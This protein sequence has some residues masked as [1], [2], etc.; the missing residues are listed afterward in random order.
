M[1]PCYGA[2]MLILSNPKYA[3][4]TLFGPPRRRA[5]LSFAALAAL[6]VTV[7]LAV[8]ACGPAPAAGSPCSTEQDTAD[9]T[10]SEG[11]S[12]TQT[13]ERCI[14]G[15][16]LFCPSGVTSGE[17]FWSGCRP[18]RPA[19]FVADGACSSPSD[20]CSGLCSKGICLASVGCK[21]DGPCTKPDDCCSG[22][23]DPGGLCRHGTCGGS[24]TGCAETSQCC[25]GI[26]GSSGRCQSECI[27]AGQ[28]CTHDAQCCSKACDATGVCAAP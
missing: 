24:D 20:C 26:C 17:L 25:S 2:N 7:S 6:V 8:S 12:R 21:T 22:Q 23:C 18:A 1:R 14:Q 11:A 15:D 16:P 27:V 28:P 3:R 9:C 4:S 13:C 10:D 19:C 5:L